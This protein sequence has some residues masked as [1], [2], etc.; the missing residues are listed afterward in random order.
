ME[1]KLFKELTRKERMDEM[2]VHVNQMLR[3]IHPDRGLAVNFLKITKDDLQSFS[4]WDRKRLGLHTGMECFII[5]EWE[6]AA[7]KSHILYVVDVSAD[8]EL[9]AMDE[10]FHLLSYKF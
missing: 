8:S 10:L 7:T 6:R 5:L 9:T 2:L 3:R 1:E 4:D